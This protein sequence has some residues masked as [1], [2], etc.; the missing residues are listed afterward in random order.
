MNTVA[1]IQ[2][3]MGSTRLPGKALLPLAGVPLIHQLIERAQRATRLD[4]V[5]VAYPRRDHDAFRF[6]L[7]A[8][9]SV[10]L[11]A[12]PG[13]EDDLIGRYVG[14][15]QAFGAQVIVRI[16]GDNPCVDPRY[17]DA[18][19]EA[20]ASDP[21]L[22]YSN[23]TAAVGDVMVDGIGAEVL[24]RSRLHWL[25]ARTQGHAEWREH[26]HRYFEACGLLSLPPATMR[27][28]V[29]TSADY[30]A[31]AALYTH[32]GQNRFTAAE[33]VAAVPLLARSRT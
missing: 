2:V 19:I 12:Y 8:T 26:P 32:F 6:L 5:V 11:Y 29:N 15:A 1:I 30:A 21:C 27:L 16:P 31:I 10:C 13:D 20:Y 9:P 3:R 14:A 4:G 33:S 25:D 17:L 28:D 22:Y 18:A 23:T 24:S 7:H